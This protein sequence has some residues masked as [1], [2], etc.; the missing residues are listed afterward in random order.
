[1]SYPT[2]NI[3]TAK[4]DGVDDVMALH[5]NELQTA[6]TALNMLTVENDSGVLTAVGDVG[7]IDETG[8]Y[9]ET[10]TAYLDGVAWCVVIVGAADGSDM[11]VV[12]RGSPVNVALNGN[13]SIGDYL[14]TSTTAGQGQ[15][16][17]YMR[18]E[19]FAV[20]LTANDEGAGGYC[21]ALLLCNTRRVPKSSANNILYVN[22]HT[23]MDW[24]T[25]IN[26]APAGAVVT[27]TAPLTSG[28]EDTIVPNAATELGKLRLYNETRGTYGLIDSV[29]IGA[30]TITLT[31]AAPGAWANTDVITTRSQTNVFAGPPP[32]YYEVDLSSADNDTIPILARTLVMDVG[33]IDTGGTGVYL[34]THPWETNAPSK[35]KA[36]RIYLANTLHYRQVEVSLFQR[37]FTYIANASGAGTKGTIFRLAAYDLAVP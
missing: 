25:T 28:A 20:A 17:S 30:N 6:A 32:Y 19:V 13:C 23:T 26:G 36:N 10:T 11:V 27:Y 15:P 31:A 5:V 34:L 9:K 37:R 21:E 4:V 8:K 35:E 33:A 18:P 1:M 2:S 7:Y 22:G 3:T 14:Y 16:Q 29:N 24:R 12:V